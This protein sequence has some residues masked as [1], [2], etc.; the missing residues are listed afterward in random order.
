MK[1]ASILLILFLLAAANL[2][3][4]GANTAIETLRT[5]LSQNLGTAKA[6]VQTTQNSLIEN[7]NTTLANN[8]T[9]LNTAIGNINNAANTLLS[10]LTTLENNINTNL[11]NIE[12]T[13]NT[14]AIQNTSPTQFSY[15]DLRT[16]M[17]NYYEQREADLEASRQNQINFFSE[18]LASNPETKDKVIGNINK[19]FEK[20]E[21]Q[22]DTNHATVINSI[23]T[24]EENYNGLQVTQ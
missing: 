6:N 12:S 9:A 24:L 22:L 19:F 16:S 1:R 18:Q 2:C 5:N 23:N 17:N 3:W 21:T 7:F 20:A 15:D 4:A 10:N 11:D 14:I 13:F 8:P